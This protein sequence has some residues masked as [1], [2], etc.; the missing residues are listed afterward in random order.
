M[1]ASLAQRP[2]E[3]S[4]SEFD[5]YLFRGD[6]SLAKQTGWLTYHTLR[7]K[8][9]RSGFPDRTLVRERVVFA[10]LKSET[11]RPT[12]EQREWL[13]ALAKAG[14][15]VYLWRPSDLD[16]IGRVLGHRYDFVRGALVGST[17]DHAGTTWIPNSLWVPEG[18]RHDAHVAN[19][20]FQSAMPPQAR[21]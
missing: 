4:E 9:S 1:R 12:D 13:T 3:W 7:S 10:E 11:G 17:L 14:A 2:E 20:R 8:G 16:D 21:Q 5:G 19:L 6:K 15:E 18:L